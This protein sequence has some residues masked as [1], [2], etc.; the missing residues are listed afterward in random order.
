MLYRST[1]EMF[2]DRVQQSADNEA[3]RYKKDGHW[4]SVTWADFGRQTR[5]IALSLLDLGLGKGDAVAIIANTRHEWETADKAINLFGGI[6]V[7]IY[8]TLPANQIEY[9]VQHSEAKAI[10]IEDA[11][12]YTKIQEIAGACPELKTLILIDPEGVE[13]G[14]WLLYADL[15]ADNQNKELEYGRVLDKLTTSIMAGDTSTYIYTSGTTGPPKGA[16]ITHA[17]FL[18]EA[19]LLIDAVGINDDDVTISWLPFSHVFQRATTAAGTFGGAP[20]AFAESID[21]LLSNISEV[22][23]TIFYSVPRVYEKAYAK[24][25]EQ[26]ENGGAL[27]KKIFYWSMNVGRQ[28]SQ[29]REKKQPIPGGLNLKYGIAKKLVF[30]KIKNV[31]G[32]RVRFIASSGAPIAKEILEF[33]HAADL[34]PLE[35]YGATEITAAVSLNLKDAYRFGTVGKAAKNTD[36]KIAPD[37]EILIRGGTVFAGYFKDPER[38]KEV[39]SEDGWYATGDIGKI[40][41]D[42]FLTITDRKRDIIVTSGGKNV[43]PQNIENMIKQSPYISQAMIHGDKRNYLTCL[44]TLDQETMTSW[45]QKQRLTVD[46]WVAFCALPE[47]VALIDGEIGKVNQSLARFET[48]KKFRIVPDDFT[49][50]AGDLTPTLKVK[51]RVVSEK[52]KNLLDAM[53]Q[54]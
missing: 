4:I 16:I 5:N 42:G 39:L 12:Q 53:Y 44:I 41:D 49:V 52:Y 1:S 34:L 17:N 11:E 13:A 18:A 32:G 36:I 28:V 2:L 27:K 38:T 37:G 24:I 22:R 20:T 33:F 30:N 29:L 9:I 6:T 15:A 19:D 31:F 14:D 21:K 47:V 43:A 46:D 7:G 35:A 50:E 25:I 51:R 40:D 48:I 8:Q 45:A 54:E 23:P 10:F 26:A 3:Y